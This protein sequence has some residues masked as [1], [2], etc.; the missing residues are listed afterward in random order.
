MS[1]MKKYASVSFLFLSLLLLVGGAGQAQNTLQP[2]VSN[3]SW[4]GKTAPDFTLKTTDGQTI[5]LCDLQGQVVLLDFWASW[6]GPCLRELPSIEKLHREFKNKGVVILGVNP[7]E[8]DVARAFV[9]LRKFTFPTVLDEDHS[10][11]QL[12]QIRAIPT[13]IVLDARGTVVAHFIG[14]RPES[15]L[16]AAIQQAQDGAA[17]TVAT[18]KPAINETAARESSVKRFAPEASPP[19]AAEPAPPAAP[20]VALEGKPHH[21]AINVVLPTYPEAAQATRVSGTVQVRLL[22]NAQGKVATVQALSGDPLLRAATIAAVKQ[23]TFKPTLT[24]GRPTP[25]EYWLT[26]VFTL[27]Q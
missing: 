23:W 9:R 18:T 3:A 1:Q 7:E 20:A 22:T 15:D 21:T 10:V 16:R 25:T 19:T 12:Y 24:Q 11:G 6:C 4:V 26:F 2:R 8:P 5:R 13:V 27:P 17:Q 14:L